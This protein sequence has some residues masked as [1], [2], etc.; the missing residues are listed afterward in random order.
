MGVGGLGV[1]G[2]FFVF[3]GTCLCLCFA[4]KGGFYFSVVSGLECG[5]RS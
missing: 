3:E 2:I 5:F 4:G 1:W